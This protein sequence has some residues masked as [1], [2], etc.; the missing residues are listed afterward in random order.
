[1]TD[2]DV[3]DDGGDNGGGHDDGD[4]HG[5]GHCPPFH[6]WI[7]HISLPHVAATFAGIW[8]QALAAADLLIDMGIRIPALT[9]PGRTA[10]TRWFGRNMISLMAV[11]TSV[12]NW[13]PSLL[14]AWNIGA[15]C[16][17]LP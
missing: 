2:S 4:D 6:Y 3:P 9:F 8:A 12:S 13:W 17:P 7:D 5:H 11:I 10:P 1:M 16:S 15:S 14:P